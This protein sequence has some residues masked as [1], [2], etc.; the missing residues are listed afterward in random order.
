MNLASYLGLV[1]WTVLVGS[2]YLGPSLPKNGQSVS[3][4]FQHLCQAKLNWREPCST[5]HQTL[6]KA[7]KDISKKKKKE[8]KKLKHSFEHVSR[9]LSLV[10]QSRSRSQSLA[11]ESVVRVVRA[12]GGQRVQGDGGRSGR[13]MDLTVGMIAA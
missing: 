10:A 4:S 12:R 7:V 13:Q 3:S 8:R 6:Q 11:V 2:H 1:C 5:S 9:C